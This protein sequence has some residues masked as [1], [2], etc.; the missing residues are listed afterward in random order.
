MVRKW[1]LWCAAFA[2]VY[3]G[4]TL[5]S[6]FHAD[7]AFRERVRRARP[8]GALPVSGPGVRITHFYA[9]T[10][11]IVRGGHS[12]VCYGVENARAVRLDPPEERLAPAMNRCFAATPQKDTTYTL[13]ATGED[14]S[15]VSESFTIQVSPPPPRILFIH[16]EKDLVKRGQR[17]AMCYGVENAVSVR[18]DPVGWKLPPSRKHCMMFFP[19][20][21]LK[22]TFTAT[23]EE[24]LTDRE[25]F[26]IKVL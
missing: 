24:G 5:V 10:G 20:A 21:T 19:P 22:Y 16:L 23:S 15:E 12:V 3:T 1:I 2:V 7:R 26:V 18:L 8:A 4:W 17:I 11:A 6:R 9:G 25:R 14:G 13:H